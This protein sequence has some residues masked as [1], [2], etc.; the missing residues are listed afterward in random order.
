ME[1]PDVEG[2]TVTTIAVVEKVI[3]VL[4]FRVVGDDV[5][6]VAKEEARATRARYVIV[7]L[8][9]CMEVDSESDDDD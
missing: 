5:R 7:L 8:V 4:V 1:E 2:G 6:Y 9:P 3:H